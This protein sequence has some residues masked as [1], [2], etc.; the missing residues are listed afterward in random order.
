MGQINP[1]DRL[2]LLESAGELADAAVD[3]AAEIPRKLKASGD[4]STAKK[5][6]VNREQDHQD[7]RNTIEHPTRM[8]RGGL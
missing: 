1:T 8:P 7:D 3:V 2:A 5:I 4:V 6:R